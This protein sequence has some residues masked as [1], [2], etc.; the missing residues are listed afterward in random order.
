[1]HKWPVRSDLYVVFAPHLRIAIWPNW[2][3]VSETI[4][5]VCV[6]FTLSIAF[7]Y[8]ASKNIRGH[9]SFL[10]CPGVF[11]VGSFRIT[12]LIYCYKRRY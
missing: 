10:C 5:Q 11:S 3:Q 4:H 2:P 1:M 8:S 12:Q 7:V 9:R 6:K